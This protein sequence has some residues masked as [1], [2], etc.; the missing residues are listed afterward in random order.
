MINKARVLT[1]R[2]ERAYARMTDLGVFKLAYQWL[3]PISLAT[4]MFGQLGFS[5]LQFRFGVA[6]PAWPFWFSLAVLNSL[7]GWRTLSRLGWQDALFGLFLLAL[8]LSFLRG[9]APAGEF[10]LQF[11][12]F[13]LLPY[14]AA[15][16]IDPQDMW[17]FILCAALVC[18]V[19]MVITVVEILSLPPTMLM[20]DRI[21]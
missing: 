1:S 2:I 15:R 14:V 4:V 9:E 17:R 10:M 12:A 3:L 20:E 8:V 19:V 16:T 7:F 6:H 5:L 21:L 18:L 13:I 11:V